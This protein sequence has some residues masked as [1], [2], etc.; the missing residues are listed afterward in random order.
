MYLQGGGGGAE[1]GLGGGG[2]GGGIVY[3]FC[4]KTKNKFGSI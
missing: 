3:S 4:S 2:G 1:R